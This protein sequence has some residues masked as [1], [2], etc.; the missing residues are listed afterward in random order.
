MIDEELREVLRDW[1]D[2]NFKDGVPDDADD[3][4][5]VIESEGYE[6]VRRGGGG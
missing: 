6:I 4:V 2:D 5:N 1:F 3:L